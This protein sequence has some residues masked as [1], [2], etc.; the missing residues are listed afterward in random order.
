MKDYMHQYEY[1]LICTKNRNEL[2]EKVTKSLNE[3]WDLHGPTM[4]AEEVSERLDREEPYFVSEN[5]FYQAMFKKT[6]LTET[7]IESIIKRRN[8]C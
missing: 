6:L 3:G 7:D 5:Y 8:Q 4:I 2:C 1:K